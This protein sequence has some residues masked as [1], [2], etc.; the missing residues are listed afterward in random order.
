MNLQDTLDKIILHAKLHTPA[1]ILLKGTIGTGKTFLTKKLAEHIGVTD[2]IASP[3]FTLLSNYY[4]DWENKKNF[5]HLDLYRLPK[6]STEQI[7]TQTNLAEFLMEDNIVVIE[8]PEKVEPYLKQFNPL[9]VNI[10]MKDN[11]RVYSINE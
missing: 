7:F 2:D 9:I 11:L 1:L 10:A 8:W 5:I 4:I 3:T 6:F